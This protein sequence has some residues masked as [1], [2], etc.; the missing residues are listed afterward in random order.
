MVFAFKTASLTPELLRPME[1]SNSGVKDAVLNAK[2]IGEVRDP[3]R[4][5]IQVIMSLL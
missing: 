5:L 2:T 4:L 3:Q 1:I